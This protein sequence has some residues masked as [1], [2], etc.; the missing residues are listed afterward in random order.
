MAAKRALDTALFY[1]AGPVAI[2][3]LFAAAFLLPNLLS[4]IWLLFLFFGLAL[5]SLLLFCVAAWRRG[6]DEV[7]KESAKFA[8]FW[9]VLFGLPLGFFGL[10]LVASFFIPH[11]LSSDG[12]I[13]SVPVIWMLA[14]ALFVYAAWLIAFLVARA[15]WWLRHR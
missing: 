1:V 9:G 8:V 10:A 15:V 14:G 7:V 6:T 5:V 3:V 11:H 12:G 4:H 2:A 13:A